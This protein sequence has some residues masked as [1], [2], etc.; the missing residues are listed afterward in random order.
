MVQ[1]SEHGG[2][3]LIAERILFAERVVHSVEVKLQQF[4]LRGGFV[5]RR[6][7]DG[8]Q[9]KDLRTGTAFLGVGLGLLEV[10]C[11]VLVEP[12]V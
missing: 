4:N 5:R 2:H 8:F 1:N 12:R 3:F 10:L 9:T 7:Q 11:L 6:A